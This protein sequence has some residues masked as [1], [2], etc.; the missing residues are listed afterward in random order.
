VRC[1]RVVIS[2]RVGDQEIIECWDASTG[3]SRWKFAYFTSFVCP[4]G[5][6]NGPYSTPVLDDERVYAIGAQGQ[7]HCLDI[8]DGRLLWHRS[9]LE[10]FSLEA[11]TFPIGA[12]PLLYNDWLIFNVGGEHGNG[13]VAF[14]KHT[15]E[16]QW[17]VTDDAASYATPIV[18]DIHGRPFAFAFTYEGLV[19]LQPDN[20]QVLW[21]IPFRP[22]NPDTI[23]ATSPLVYDDLL[24]LSGYQLGALCL[25][26]RADGTYR[27]LWRQRRVLDSQYNNLVGLDGCVFGFSAVDRSLRCVDV[28]SGA[29]HWKWRS[30]LGR[31]NCL[32][33]ADHLL[34]LGQ[35]GH[36]A[37]V[38]PTADRPDCRAL[39]AD[40]LLGGPCYSAPALDEGRLF[41]RNEGTLLCIDLRSAARVRST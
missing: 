37:S 7:F 40:S 35:A 19:A 23:I 41:L 36:L 5:Y 1:G 34:I 8:N 39:T 33:V 6:S 15:G 30:I 10:E 3:H 9:F 27:E 13:I 22:K 11:G 4:V 21:R 38:R 16:T 2:H 31:G 24:V 18:A 17:S 14:D 20:G 32:A 25:Q 29:L 26:I 12:S 28:R